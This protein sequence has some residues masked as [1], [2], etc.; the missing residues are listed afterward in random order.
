ML[1]HSGNGLRQR[2]LGVEM[3]MTI[4]GPAFYWELPA[5]IWD[6]IDTFV[7]PREIVG[8]HDQ[9]CVCGRIHY[10]LET[11]CAKPDI[12]PPPW[13]ADEPPYR[14]C[15]CWYDCDPCGKCGDDPVVLHGPKPPGS[16]PEPDPEVSD[17]DGFDRIVLGNWRSDD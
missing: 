11:A 9:P 3:T 2:D 10:T 13:K 1:L 8:D 6:G 14:H 7:S 16:A 17:G 4:N 15:N 5:E 12:M